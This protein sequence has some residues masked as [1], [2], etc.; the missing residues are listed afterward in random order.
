VI[1][2]HAHVHDKVFDA[3]RD[4]VMQRAKAAGIEG[5]IMVGCD[6][7]DSRRA[8]ETARAYGTCASAGVHPHEARAAPEDLAAAL[9]PVLDDP[10]AVAVGETGLD[11]YYDHSPRELQ[12]RVLRTQMRVA[13]ERDLPLIFHV[14]EAHER[15]IEV[16]RE[17]ASPGLR[18]VVH[19]FTGDAEQ[20][21]G[22]VGEFGL[23]LG[24]GGIV[25][26]RN[27]TSIHEAVRAV[28]LDALLLETDCPYLA[29][30]P[31]RGRRNEPAFVTYTVEQLAHVLAV[32]P[33]DV[34]GATSRNALRLFGRA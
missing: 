12:E 19:C 25:T 32:A 15:M 1:D 18:G 34:I 23:F 8:L 27:A 28:G 26:F 2:T 30:V 4:E 21:K 22:Y 16:L 7:Q 31:M 29:P 5:V 17:Q 3:D 20:A 14:R 10:S 24:I 6:L 11:F 13:R 33:A 9:S